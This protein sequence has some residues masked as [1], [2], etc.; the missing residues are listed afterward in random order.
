MEKE[1]QELYVRRAGGR[2]KREVVE[3]VGNWGRIYRENE[4]RKRHRKRELAQAAD[5]V[6]R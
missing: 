6:M 2:G 3:Y 4:G 1:S 5:S